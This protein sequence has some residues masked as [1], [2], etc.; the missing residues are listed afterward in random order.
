MD[1]KKL[2]Q[3]GISFRKKVILGEEVLF[4]NQDIV[5]NISYCLSGY[6]DMQP[7]TEYLVEEL[8]V[9]IDKAIQGVPF[10]EDGGYVDIY[11]ELGFPNSTFTSGGGT[12]QLIETIPTV[13]LKEIILSWV[14]F[15]ENK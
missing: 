8:L 13:D 5:S 11:L 12:N 6:L 3:Y 15:L 1:I 10:E 4:C 9:E 2:E 14:E 7:Y